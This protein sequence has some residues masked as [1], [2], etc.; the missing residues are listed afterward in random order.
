MFS[1]LL[2][3]IAKKCWIFRRDPQK[4]ARRIQHSPVQYLSHAST[5]SSGTTLLSLTFFFLFFLPDA[6]YPRDNCSLPL[7]A[8]HAMHALAWN[9]QSFSPGTFL[10]SFMPLA[11]FLFSEAIS[12]RY[13]CRHSGTSFLPQWLTTQVIGIRRIQIFLASVFSS[14]GRSQR[15]QSLRRCFLSGFL[16]M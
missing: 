2:L 6:A 16:S 5:K 13:V 9:C 4:T 15:Q 1:T 12:A 8:M 7:R 10:V 14:G 3:V 11:F